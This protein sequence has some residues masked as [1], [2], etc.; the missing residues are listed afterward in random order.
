MPKFQ[1]YLK[2]QVA[3][4]LMILISSQNIFKNARDRESHYTQ[5]L[6]QSSLK[7]QETESLI[8]LKYCISHH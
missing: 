4:N 1:S 2:I 5:I 3:G 6:Y 7:T 8:I